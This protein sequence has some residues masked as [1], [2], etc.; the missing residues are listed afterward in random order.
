MAWTYQQILEQ[1]YADVQAEQAEI[2]AAIER[3]RVY[4]DVEGL[5]VAIERHD[6]NQ[7]RLQSLNNAALAMQRTQQQPA[8][9]EGLTREQTRLAKK[10]GLSAEEAQ[11]ALNTTNAPELDDADKMVLYSEGKQKYQEWRASNPD[12]RDFQGKVRR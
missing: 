3:A 9:Y 2:N 12:E 5:N 1:R 11:I 7:S 10:N 4:E 8:S 6:A